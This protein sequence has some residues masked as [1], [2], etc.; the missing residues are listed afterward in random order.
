MTLDNLSR[1]YQVSPDVWM[2]FAASYYLR[3]ELNGTYADAMQAINV[4]VLDKFSEEQKATQ[5]W[6]IHRT[7]AALIAGD[8]LSHYPPKPRN[9]RS[10]FKQPL[11][12]TI[13]TSPTSP[14]AI[15]STRN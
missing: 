10:S 7:R 13:S 4:L 9:N 2:D 6:Q 11:E 5:I 12:I 3:G 8:T 14:T 15:N 1:A